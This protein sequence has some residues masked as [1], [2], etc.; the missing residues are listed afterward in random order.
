MNFVH[1][2]TR[3]HTVLVYG[4]QHLFSVMR[5]CHA[6]QADESVEISQVELGDSTRRTSASKKDHKSNPAVLMQQLNEVT[7]WQTVDA[8]IIDGSFLADVSFMCPRFKV[9]VICDERVDDALLI[10]LIKMKSMLIS[11]RIHEDEHGARSLLC[12]VLP[13]AFAHNER[14]KE[15]GAFTWRPTLIKSRRNKSLLDCADGTAEAAGVLARALTPRHD[16]DRS[17]RLY[18]QTHS[19]FTLGRLCPGI[20][21]NPKGWIFVGRTGGGDGSMTRAQLIA[22]LASQFP[23]TGRAELEDALDAPWEALSEDGVLSRE[24]FL[25]GE[26]GL[27]HLVRRAVLGDDIVAAEDRAMAES[28]DATQAAAAANV[29]ANPERS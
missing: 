24:E 2:Q 18:S 29:A 25:D 23:S 16:D 8:S 10:E 28:N 6:A 12:F 7:E 20:A 26:T 22:V 15:R 4:P 11:F 5:C 27:L 17:A 19:K 14:W 13:K 21:A 3:L 9:H 1:T